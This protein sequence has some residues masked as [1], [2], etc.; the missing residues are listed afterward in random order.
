M[1][2]VQILFVGR[3]RVQKKHNTK[4]NIR[5]RAYATVLTLFLGVSLSRLF[6]RINIIPVM[7]M[8]S[9]IKRGRRAPRIFANQTAVKSATA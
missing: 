4:N 3:A 2:Y 6:D 5:R 1:T 9:G 8:S 7:Q